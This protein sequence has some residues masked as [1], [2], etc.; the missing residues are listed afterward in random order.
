M[1]ARRASAHPYDVLTPDCVLHALEAVGM[2]PDGRLLALNSFENRVYQAGL[3]DGCFVVAKFY[4]P[5]RWSD[6]AILEEHRFVRELAAAELPVTQPLEVADATL[7]RHAGF[8]FALYPRCGGRPPELQGGD[9][10]A[11]IGRTLARMHAVGARCAFEHRERMRPQSWVER[12]AE[13][14]LR[15]GLLP[16]ALRQHYEALVARALDA[17]A[18][19]P[20]LADLRQLRIH[21]DC[22]AGNIL[23][24]A[25]GPYWLDF[26]DAC[27][28]P[29][30]QDLWMLL[31]DEEPLRQAMLEGYAEFRE[32]PWGEL[33]CI[34]AL[35]LVR[36]MHYAGWIA[37]RWEDPAF[38]R[39]FPWA[40]SAQYWET[41][42][43]D[44]A[45][46]LETVTLP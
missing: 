21:G 9:A 6:A 36:Q 8:R 31:P 34:G 24:G 7:H 28:G 26:D 14:V 41:H 3:S 45:D 44:I 42:V 37:Q 38:P 16:V 23:W 4:R 27:M 40:A 17:F 13:Q 33:G 11:W 5:N 22:H 2:Q 32:L 30:V 12:A 1:T 18:A 29:A 15:S 25:Q 35:R 19:H 20:Y 39:S 10:A 46:A 43:Q